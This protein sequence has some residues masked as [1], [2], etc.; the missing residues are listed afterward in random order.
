MNPPFAGTERVLQSC[1][2]PIHP[3]GRT[4]SGGVVLIEVFALKLD[5]MSDQQFSVRSGHPDEAAMEAIRIE[6]VGDGIHTQH[7]EVGLKEYLAGKE[8]G[9]GENGVHL[10][11]LVQRD[12]DPAGADIDGSLNERSLRGI[13][14][15]LKTD[16]Q[17]NGDAIVVA[18]LST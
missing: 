15:R 1:P 18:A 14:L 10:E 6:R 17:E 9:T 5:D 11:D 16:G 4:Y 8:Q 2:G 12:A 7:F 3:E 13:A